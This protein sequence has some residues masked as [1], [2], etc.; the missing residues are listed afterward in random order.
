MEPRMEPMEQALFM[1]MQQAHGLPGMP[2]QRKPPFKASSA[3]SI[4]WSKLLV[5]TCLLVVDLA[6]FRTSALL[7]SAR[8]RRSFF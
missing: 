4:L 5:D 8:G 2:N 3:A 6:A 1:N 7:C